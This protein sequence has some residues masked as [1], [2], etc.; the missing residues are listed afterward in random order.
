MFPIENAF[1]IP[2]GKRK[3]ENFFGFSVGD[4]R[5]APFFGFPD[6]LTNWLTN[7]IARISFSANLNGMSNR[8]PTVTSLGVAAGGA[9]N[10]WAGGV[11]G[12]DGKIYGIPFSSSN[13]L[14]ID[15]N[16]DTIITNLFNLG[17]A[18]SKF[19]GGC[20]GSNGRIYFIPNANAG[21]V[22]LDYINKIVT[23]FGTTTGY[24]YGCLAQNDCIYTV[25][26]DI[27]ELNTRSKSI[28]NFGSSGFT[29][30]ANLCPHPNGKLYGL[31]VDAGTTW[32]AGIEIDPINRTVVNFGAITTVA[33]HAVGGQVASNGKIY[34]TAS[35][36]TTCVELDPYLKTLSTFGALGSS[37]TFK[38]Q[39]SCM[40][41]NG[42]IYGANR[43]ASTAL[44]I[45]PI[46]KTATTFSSGLSTNT[47]VGIVLAPNNK[48]YVIPF[49][50]TDV[51]V[52]DFSY[53]QSFGNDMYF[54]PYLNKL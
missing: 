36:G 26:T 22:E 34:F 39:G 17:A 8:Q 18:V 10:K 24:A 51:E 53:L 29:A 45:D 13:I 40:A 37:G 43:A 49:T 2:S 7:W 14:I 48:A 38:W 23:T 6:Q 27:V 21:F 30:G 33:N 47:K 15:P 52:Y 3:W 32:A 46:N 19:I 25:G 20:M 5:E 4:R 1:G 50:H 54:S 12:L 35:A 42:K 9:A 11:L 44:E 41:P 28:T 31:S 16:T